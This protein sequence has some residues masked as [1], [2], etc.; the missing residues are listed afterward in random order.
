MPAAAPTLLEVRHETRYD[1]SAPVTLAHHL[2]HLR[3]L[4]DTHQRLDR[5]ALDVSPAPAQA[6]GGWWQPKVVYQ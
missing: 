2:A 3:P 6:A 5:F 1:Y 4:T